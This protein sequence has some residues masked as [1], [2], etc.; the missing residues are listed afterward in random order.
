MAEKISK[1]W[2]AMGLMSFFCLAISLVILALVSE[3]NDFPG[4]YDNEPMKTKIDDEMPEW[5]IGRGIP[6][7]LLDY[8]KAHGRILRNTKSKKSRFIVY[9]IPSN[10]SVAFDS[11]LGLVSTFV[12]AI[13]TDRALLLNFQTIGN[14]SM[15]THVDI[16]DMFTTPGFEWDWEAFLQ[17][18]HLHPGE[19][20]MEH[21]DPMAHMEEITCSDLALLLEKKKFVKITSQ[22]FFMPLVMV[23]AHYSQL[24]ET[25]LGFRMAFADLLNF[26]LRP[27]K[28]VAESIRR[29]RRRYLDGNIVIGI[30][31]S[32]MPG[33]G[34]WEGDGYM[35]DAQQNLFFS[36]A[37]TSLE[38]MATAAKQA[39]K[40]KATPDVSVTGMG[41]SFSTQSGSSQG[42]VDT[43]EAGGVQEGVLLDPTTENGAVFLVVTDNEEQLH[44]KFQELEAAGNVITAGIV[45]ILSATGVGRTRA[46]LEVQELWLLGYADII[47]TTPG[48]RLG[49]TAAA[50]AVLQPHVVV[51]ENTVRLSTAPYPCLASFGFIQHSSCFVPSMLSKYPPDSQVPCS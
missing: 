37:S 46:A 4:F 38:M 44:T 7:M 29:F 48:S 33:R 14:S 24:L 8:A 12:L 26:L 22:D 23:N 10:T 2:K 17:A 11:F 18:N 43:I 31:L 45:A 16:G 51:D 49:I 5:F 3:L 9:E 35:S 40:A 47:L 27:S 36:H 39:A 25:K 50:R 28:A 1:R 15:T 30:E 34:V 20:E 32:V 19:L 13:V 6:S 42:G 41:D 21:W